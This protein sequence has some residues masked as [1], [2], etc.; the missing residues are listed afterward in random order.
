MASLALPVGAQERR[1]ILPTASKPST[2]SRLSEPRVQLV[3]ILKEAEEKSPE[4]QAAFNRYK[5]AETR[6]SQERTLPDPTIGFMATNMGKALPFTT[7]GEDPQS[8]AGVSFTQEIP[9]P[10]KLSL[11]GDI[12][13]QEAKNAFEEYRG[14]KLEVLSRVKAAYYE[15][16]SLQRMDEI[17]TQNVGA[18]GKLAKVAQR[19][20]EAGSGS[21]QDVLKAEV[22]T[23]IAR[24]RLVSIDQ[25]RGSALAQL[26]ALLNR[27]PEA[28]LGAPEPLKKTV[29]K[30]SFEEL[31]DTATAHSP[32]LNS[33]KALVERDQFGV[34][35]ARRQYYPD[36]MIGGYYGNS[37]DLPSMWQW[38]LDLKV[39]FYYRSKQQYAVKEAAY[40]LSRSQ[41]E[42]DA[43]RQGLN[44]ALKDEYLR[45]RAS[46]KL[47]D[48]YSNKIV[49]DSRL[50]FESSLQS[51][52][53]GQVDFL[54]MLTNLV[55]AR[56]YEIGYVEELM[57]FLTALA[58][59]EAMVGTP[60]EEKLSRGSK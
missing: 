44:A 2:A 54:S 48:L 56:D 29:L 55:I 25:K 37:G 52:Q 31:A 47:I 22:E 8:N 3:E 36:F 42:R 21:Q 35:Y 1:D 10:G 53:T 39:P 18:L 59:I 24:A 32:M 19:R 5:A 6:P 46:E 16:A 20:Y 14:T 17:L 9:F 4:I 15:Y 13:T 7:I 34:D 12:A 58:R 11:K 43:T 51:Y 30:A 41:N 27:A 23:S 60:I 40:N 49:R 45:A 38:R 50:A 26:N 28:A 57:N 33:R